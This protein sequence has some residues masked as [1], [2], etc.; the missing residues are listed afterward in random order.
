MGIDRSYSAKKIF[1]KDY[2]TYYAGVIRHSILYISNLAKK[3][4][5]IIVMEEWHKEIIEKVTDKKIYVLNVSDGKVDEKKRNE[6]K[7]KVEKI[8]EELLEK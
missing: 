8:L 5:Y 7:I 6:I 2:E 1:E 3:A 4:D